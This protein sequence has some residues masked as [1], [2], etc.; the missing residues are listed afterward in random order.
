MGDGADTG[1]RLADE[2]P[3]RAGLDR[4]VD[5]L[6]GEAPDQPRTAA[7]VAEMRP[8]RISPVTRLRASKVICVR[9]RSNPATIVIG[10]PL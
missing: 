8:R 7:G 2:Q 5:L 10:S 9:C 4:N 1:Q 6:P 3:T